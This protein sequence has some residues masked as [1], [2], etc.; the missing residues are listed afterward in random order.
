MLEAKKLDTIRCG[1][2]SLGGIGFEA[3]SQSIGF[4]ANWV[5]LGLY[6]RKCTYNFVYLGNITPAQLYGK[7][8][9]TILHG[10]NLPN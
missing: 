3:Q 5:D 9:S 6:V 8:S 10:L 1:S 2:M 7:C 4:W